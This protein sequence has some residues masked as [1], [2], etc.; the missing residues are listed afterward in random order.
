MTTELPTA[1]EV[2]W[3]IDFRVKIGATAGK[4]LAGLRDRRIR[5]T[6]CSRCNWVYVPAQSYCE[7]CL[8]P[9]D[10]W[11]DV[12][13]SGVLDSFTVVH[14]APG[15]PPP[16]F[17]LGSIH[18]DGAD[19]LLQ[20][21]VGGVEF[22]DTGRPMHLQPGQRVEAVWKPERSGSILD[23]EHFVAVTR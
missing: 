18:L 23:I 2:R 10:E 3:D 14:L 22:D 12:A 9:A 17:V 4:F 1:I 21:Y 5:G 13:T 16:P 7:R 6:R 19:G 15:G 8:E 11:V 20:H